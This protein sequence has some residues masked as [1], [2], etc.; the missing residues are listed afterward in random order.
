MLGLRRSSLVFCCALLLAGAGTTLIS[1][2]AAQP[3]PGEDAAVLAADTALANA[4]RAGDRSAARRLLSLEFS[5]V[6]EDGGLHSRKEFLTGLTALA[7]AP[8]TGVN[9]KVYGLVAM[10]TGHRQSAHGSDVFFLDI[11]A[12]E[13]RA[14][15]ALVIQDVALPAED[16]PGKAS[17]ADED[18]ELRKRL[19]EFSDCK[20][21]CE[22]IPYRVRSP[23][24]QDIVTAFQAAEKAFV[25]HN[26]DEYARHFADSFVHYESGLPPIPK[27]E[28]LAHIEQLKANGA[29]AIMPPVQTMR[30][31]VFG[32]GAAMIS[33]N[34][35]PNETDP[36]LRI[37]R[38]WAKRN[39][40][41]LME[42]S[43]QTLVK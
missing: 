12:K 29:P 38:V 6:D 24:E 18:Q 36:L 39:G 13:K 14:W 43:V 40:Q 9:V 3:A 31:W 10:V 32:E 28:R 37:A 41:W 23:A 30:L 16:A 5:E 17:D 42:I 11:W 4:M 8:A 20:N 35:A 21:P 22:T 19:A 1:R 33:A 7:P 26:A 25:A 34:G 2:L 27:S 15:R